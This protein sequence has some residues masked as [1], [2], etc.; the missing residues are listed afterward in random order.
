MK[1]AVSYES[2]NQK[3][4]EEERLSLIKKKSES[5]DSLDIMKK[6]ISEREKKLKS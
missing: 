2:V 1:S 5:E 4:R 3:K 6:K